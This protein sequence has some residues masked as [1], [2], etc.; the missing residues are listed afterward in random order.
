MSGTGKIA[1]AG[2]TVEL[3]RNIAV[4]V[5]ARL[6]FIMTNTGDEAMTMYVINEPCPAGFRPNDKL[7]ARD[8]QAPRPPRPPVPN[9]LVTPGAAGHWSHITR[10]L[11]ATADGL[12][13]IQGLITVSLDPLTL[14]EPHPHGPGREEVWLAIEGTS[15]AWLG[16]E[17]RVQRPGMAYNARPDRVVTHSNVNFGDQ[18]VKF[19]WFAGNG[20]HELRK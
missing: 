18:R 17:L 14:G 15:L 20:E 13:A 5:P 2:E 10:S 8:E 19:L 11:F 6:D 1:A 12:G 3:H 9:P 16:T 4:L 7:L